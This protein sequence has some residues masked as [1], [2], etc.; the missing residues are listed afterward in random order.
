M[1]L[2]DHLKENPF[3]LA[4][5]A[6]ITEIA[7]R[8][9][10]KEM[11]SSVMVSELVSASGIK[12]GSE[13]TFKLMR[14]SEM[15]SP[16]GIQ[17]FGET[18][19]IIA[20]G[21]KFVQ[22]K[23]AD[24]VDLNFGCPVKKVVKKGAGSA[25]L[26]DLVQLRDI[27]RT[28]K[29]SIDIPLTI[30]I[31]TGWSFETRNAIDVCQVAYDEGIE[32]VAIHGRDRNQ[33]YKG[34]ADWDYIGEVKANSKIPILGNGDVLDA[35]TANRRLKET[36]VDGV[37]IG[38]GA[39]KNP[40]IFLE[41]LALHK[42]LSFNPSDRDFMKS[43]RRLKFY[44]DEYCDERIIKIQIR[45][46]ASWFS[47]GYPGSASFRKGLFQSETADDAMALIQEFSQNVQGIAQEDTAGDGFL[48]GGH[49]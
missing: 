5:M 32:W 8:S 37:M 15:E 34:F 6:G 30:K 47:A 20:E 26:K 24:F 43:F 48:M 4:P 17:L 13:Q 33:A 41:S 38:R 1:N 12:Y 40:Y 21:A 46:F 35:H 10:M 27:L 18:P 39:L 7:F 29:S 36:D 22:D 25:V 2:S 31:R 49:G 45:K 9:F 3:V 23:G 28:V 11:G 44:L 42:G 16:V 19:E 14:F